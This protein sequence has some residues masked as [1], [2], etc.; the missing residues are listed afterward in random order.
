MQRVTKYK[1]DETVMCTHSSWS[2]SLPHYYWHAMRDGSMLCIQSRW[3]NNNLCVTTAQDAKSLC[4]GFLNN[5][6]K[7]IEKIAWE[8]C[9]TSLLS[10]TYLSGQ[11]PEMKV[12][13]IFTRQ[14]ENQPA[15][16]GKKG[17]AE[18]IQEWVVCLVGGVNNFLV[19]PW[20]G[21]WWI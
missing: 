15:K 14:K 21:V 11:L 10:I 20:R 19:L 9:L 4:A 12:G 6:L 8:Q 5:S 16:F 17:S 18:K 3:C 1:I 7:N 13:S 2:W